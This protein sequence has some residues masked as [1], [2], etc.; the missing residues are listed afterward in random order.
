MVPVTG[1]DPL[2]DSPTVQR[3]AQVRTAIIDRLHPAI[4]NKDRDGPVGAAHDHDA[5]TLQVRQGSDTQ[6]RIG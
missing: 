5:L 6:Q 2:A 4:V 3:K 1:E